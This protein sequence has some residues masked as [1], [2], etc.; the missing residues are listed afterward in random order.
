MNLKDLFFTLA[1]F[2]ILFTISLYANS[3]SVEVTVS[4]K[5]YEQDVD[6][7]KSSQKT[8]NKASESKIT[9]EKI[10]DINNATKKE[11]IKIKGIGEVIAERIIAYRLENGP[12]Q[13]IDELIEVKGIG[14][15]KLSTIR[16]EAQVN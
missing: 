6:S 10:I 8:S 4:K 3:K 1:T 7:L 15:K 13:S 16:N 2:L 11:L 14:E 12:F 9:I 5:T